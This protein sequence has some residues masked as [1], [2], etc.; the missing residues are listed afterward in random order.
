MKIFKTISIISII[1]A[2]LVIIGEIC[3]SKDKIIKET[4]DYL[5]VMEYS[6]YNMDSVVYKYKQTKTYNG[7]VIDKNKNSHFVGV[8]GK[9]G[10]MQTNYYLTVKFN[11][12]ETTIEDRNL[13]NKYNKGDEVKVTEQFYP[14]H[15]I[16]I[17]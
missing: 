11:N 14:Y 3:N 12:T 4:P 6:L 15:S 1:I 16:T 5:Y 13:Y 17:Q 9:G 7:I 8:V 10:H 2:I